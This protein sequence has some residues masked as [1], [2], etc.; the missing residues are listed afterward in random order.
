MKIFDAESAAGVSGFAGS[1]TP[2][3]I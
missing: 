2:L 3:G 1:L